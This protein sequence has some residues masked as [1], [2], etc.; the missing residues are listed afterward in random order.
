MISELYKKSFINIYFT[1]KLYI[2]LSPYINK[3]K[4][5]R[6]WLLLCDG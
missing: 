4:L 5:N 3:F 6:N 2:R 1:P